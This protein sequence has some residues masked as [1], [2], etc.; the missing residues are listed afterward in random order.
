MGNGDGTP[1]NV[2]SMANMSFGEKAEMGAVS[3]LEVLPLP[4]VREPKKSYGAEDAGEVVS[5]GEPLLIFKS[6][7]LLKT[8]W[9]KPKLYNEGS[10]ELSGRT[11]L[12]V[13][14]WV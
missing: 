9:G 12:K 1:T 13:L 2:G 3:G 8:A 4:P 10:A 11:G 7:G 14:D 6:E 5:L